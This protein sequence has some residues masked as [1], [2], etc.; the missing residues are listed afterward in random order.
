MEPNGGLGV[1]YVM[2]KNRFEK[3]TERN[4]KRTEE[5]TKGNVHSQTLMTSLYAMTSELLGNQAKTN[6]P[7]LLA[8]KTIRSPF[9]HH[10]IIRNKKI[11]EGTV[12]RKQPTWSLN[13]DIEDSDY[14]RGV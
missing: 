14:P 10:Q 12:L 2:M 13:I 11:L 7:I 5:R 9:Q 6:I 8:N 4:L 1:R 3:N